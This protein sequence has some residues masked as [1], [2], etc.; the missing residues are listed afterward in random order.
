VRYDGGMDELEGHFREEGNRALAV[1]GLYAAGFGGVV[2]AILLV[3]IAV[4]HNSFFVMPAIFSF[5]CAIYAGGLTAM[6]RRRR[7]HGASGWAMMMT[8]VSLPSAFFAAAELSFDG[9]AA[10]FIT[11]A[12]PFL[13]LFTIVITGFLF[14]P[15]LSIVAGVFAAAQFMTLFVVSRPVL[16]RVAAPTELLQLDLVSS[17]V[18]LNKAFMMVGVGLAV[19]ALSAI[20][21]RL[22]GRV[23]AEE[24]EKR[25]ISGVFGQYVSGE[26]KDAILRHTRESKGERK[27]VAVLFSDLR[28]FST[29]A[30][31]RDPAEVV[32]R[33]NAYLQR[34]VAAIQAEG[35]VVDK[36]IG[37]AVMAVFGGVLE[38]PDPASAA[39]RAARRMRQSLAELNTAWRAE[40]L[41]PFES[42]IGIHYGEVLQGPIGSEHRK[43][44]TVIGDAVNTASRIEGL[45]KDKGASLLVTADLYERLAASERA[46]FQPLGET[47]VKGRRQSLVIYGSA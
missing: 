1:G 43:E 22:I 42:G 36:F 33:L 45:T 37:D 30:E 41:E 39:V 5:G 14:S 20:S 40:G 3:V 23:I 31:G 10:N 17:V 8:F 6:A 21:R 26:V 7:I 34:M 18:Y 46:G 9:G 25:F 27:Q 2:G 35:G 29:F 28:G 15:R 4:T 24:R 16:L 44:F 19:G 32:A 47:L 11:G 38:L 13:Y 12:I